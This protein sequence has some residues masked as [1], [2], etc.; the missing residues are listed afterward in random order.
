M[1]LGVMSI[2]NKISPVQYL[3]Y[4]PDYIINSVTVPYLNKYLRLN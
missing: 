1:K 4:Y 3:C 2:K